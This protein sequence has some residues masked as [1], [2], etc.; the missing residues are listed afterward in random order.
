MRDEVSELMPKRSISPVSVSNNTALVGQVVDCKGF[1]SVSYVIVVGVAGTT[2]ATFAVTLDHGNAAD[3]SDAAAVPSADLIGTYALASFTGADAN[4]A[5]KLGYKGSKRYTRL[6]VTPSGN[7][8]AAIIGVVAV[9]GDAAV[10]PTANPP[11]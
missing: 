2:E 1:N 6:T 4:K 3:F 7:S 11:V 10:Q 5:R 8:A 9:L